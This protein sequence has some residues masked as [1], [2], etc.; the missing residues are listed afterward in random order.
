MLAQRQPFQPEIEPGIS[1]VT[2]AVSGLRKEEDEVHMRVG[3]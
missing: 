2:D 3:V 1:A